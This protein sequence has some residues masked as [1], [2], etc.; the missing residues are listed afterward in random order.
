MSQIVF[1]EKPALDREQSYSRNFT[2]LVN[3][4]PLSSCEISVIVPVRNE[5]ENIEAT[6]LALTNQVELDGS[7]LDKKRYEIIVLAN[8]CSDDSAQIARQFAKSQP[9]L[10]LHVVEMTIARDRA[11]IGWVRKILMD[12]ACRRLK[13]IGRELGVIASTDGDTQVAP[14][15]IAATLAEFETGAD[16]VGGRII[17]EPSQRKELD[18]ATRLYFLRTVGYLYLIFQ[19]EGYLDP[20][21]CDPN[22]RHHQH[23]GASLAVTAQMYAKVGGLPPIPSSED[24]ALYDALIRNDACFRHSQTVQVLTSARVM[25]RAK[26]GLA[27]RLAQLK[28]MGEKHESFL[29]ESATLI[30]ARFRIRRHLRYLWRR[31]QQGISIS[32]QI[33]AILSKFLGIDA[34][35]LLEIIMR[36]PT[37]GILVEQIAQEQAKNQELAHIWAKVTIQQAISELR[38]KVN[39]IS[40]FNYSSLKQQEYKYLVSLNSLK[41]IKPILILPEP[42]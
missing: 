20:Y 9:D 31:K 27:D 28:V 37:F 30:E 40:K 32:N 8:N 19:L 12:E 25:G 38:I 3:Q 15:W 1:W 34:N 26:A 7:P 22:P 42:F 21:I 4:L 24:V 6:L 36:S 35:L 41:H 39:R 11:H 29:V 5:A 23:Y 16:A 18:N 10:I 33:I 14:T 17:T 2:P 13:L